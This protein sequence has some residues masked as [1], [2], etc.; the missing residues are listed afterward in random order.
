M[1]SLIWLIEEFP[2]LLLVVLRVV[3]RQH[4]GFCY[5]GVCLIWAC[6]CFQ[7]LLV[8]VCKHF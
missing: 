1:I 4:R 2:N 5:L 3:L 7:H 6:L 8:E